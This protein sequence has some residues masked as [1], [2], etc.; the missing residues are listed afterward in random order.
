[1]TEQF[2]F[3]KPELEPMWLFAAVAGD[4]GTGKSYSA[5]RLM[6]GLIGSD[7]FAVIDTEQGRASHYHKNRLGAR[8]FDFIS[9]RLDAPYTPERY[10]AAAQAAIQTGVKGLII[11]SGSHL[12]ESDGGVQD[13]A[14][15]GARKL[16]KQWNTS[17]DKAQFAAWREPKDRMWKLI[18]FLDKAPIHIIVCLRAKHRYKQVKDA[19]GRTQIVDIGYQ[20]LIESGVPFQFQFCALFEP[21]APGIPT[22]KVKPIAEQ[23]KGML[24]KNEPMNEEQGRRLAKWLAGPGGQPKSSSPVPPPE[25][26]HN[27]ETG[28]VHDDEGRIVDAPP[29][30]PND[31]DP[32]KILGIERT[33]EALE[34]LSMALGN[35]TNKV[36]AT[37]L[38]WKYRDHFA[39]KGNGA[40]KSIT[41]FEEWVATRDYD[42]ETSSA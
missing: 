12:W 39:A 3:T 30:D 23:F 36:E 25:H 34:V 29:P 37:A 28:D 2:A 40:L 31:P 9:C 4:T 16:A 33:K 20:P 7:D 13:Q 5:M 38:L 1:M 17:V 11:D 19:N 21:G 35:C 27:T 14:E 18:W 6:R 32:L 24:D 26:H 8:G 41:A 15:Q 10:Q 42:A 22:W